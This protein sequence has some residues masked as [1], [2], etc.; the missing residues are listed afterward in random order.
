MIAALRQLTAKCGNCHGTGVLESLARA[1]VVNG[2]PAMLVPH[3]ETCWG[4]GELGP[5][6]PL[7]MK[8]VRKAGDVWTR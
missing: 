4:A 2:L 7:G 6:H 5:G 8:A 3:C 1:G